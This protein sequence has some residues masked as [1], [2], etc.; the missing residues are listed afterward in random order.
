MEPGPH[1]LTLRESIGGR[2][3]ATSVRRREKGVGAAEL[4]VGLLLP[5]YR[6]VPLARGGNLLPHPRRPVRPP[7][8][9]FFSSA[10]PPIPAGSERTHLPKGAGRKRPLLHPSSVGGG[11][12]GLLRMGR[13]TNG[14]TGVGAPRPPN[15]ISKC[16]FSPTI[17]SL[18]S[19]FPSKHLLF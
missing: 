8:C 10:P 19:P 4:R 14:S 2:G 18:A 6:A 13:S 15:G 3:R 16:D 9:A 17:R 1:P 7:F 12:A 5:W 11:E